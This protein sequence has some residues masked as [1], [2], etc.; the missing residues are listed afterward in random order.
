MRIDYPPPANRG[1][2]SEFP[3]VTPNYTKIVEAFSTVNNSFRQRSLFDICKEVS[4]YNTPERV[5]RFFGVEYTP[6]GAL[7]PTSQKLRFDQFHCHKNT[8]SPDIE[9]L[10]EQDPNRAEEE[11][12][13]SLLDS[14]VNKN[15]RH[16]DLSG[17][18]GKR[19]IGYGAQLYPFKNEYGDVVQTVIKLVNWQNAS[20]RLIP[21]ASW[22]YDYHVQNMFFCVPYPQKK[23]ILYNLDLL[24][25]VDTPTVILTDSIEIAELNQTKPDS[26]RIVWTSWLCD[27]TAHDAYDHV[28]WSPLEKAGQVFLLIT[29][30]SGVSLAEAYPKTKTLADYLQKNEEIE[31]LKY[32]QVDIDF[33][34]LVKRGYANM[35][36]YVNARLD[37]RPVIAPKGLFSLEGDEFERIHELAVDEVRVK[38][39]K[40]YEKTRNTESDNADRA[41]SGDNDQKSLPDYLLRPVIARR[42]ITMLHAISGQGKTMFASSLCA[43]IVTRKA[44]IES[45]WWTCPKDGETMPRKVLYFD[46]EMGN[47]DYLARIK[48]S[49]TPYIPKKDM[50]ENFIIQDML[51][52]ST[53]Y[54]V[55]ANHQKI[56]N[57]IKAAKEQGTP[58]Q[59]VDL[60]VFDSYT[61]L[62]G[63]DHETSWAKILRLM[64][65]I[66]ET[67]AGILLIHHSLETSGKS[68]GSDK[69]KHDFFV[70]LKLN[71]AAGAEGN[72]NDPMLVEGEKWRG[73]P[74]GADKK[75][76]HVRLKKGG[77]W[78]ACPAELP[79]A[80][81]RDNNASSTKKASRATEEAMDDDIELRWSREYLEIIKHYEEVCKLNRDEIAW[82][83][84]YE[85]TRCNDIKRE[86]EAYLKMVQEKEIIADK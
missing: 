60:V 67:N 20:K 84:G 77:K 55:E 58:G 24:K 22:A 7:K 13:E 86:R 72:L 42:K 26:R 2:L 33:G 8:E 50:R 40:F 37:S 56:L 63:G 38:K 64:K 45:K 82:L 76:F 57:L 71:R 43:A 5:C 9:R 53:D 1:A 73:N 74:S 23:Q 79:E 85:K 16:V 25:T 80:K 41:T 31:K 35:A 68:T 30:H 4:P 70:Q 19:Y 27:D 46:F 21:C 81:E 36:S 54:L 65:K 14:W 17:Y 78:E 3:P 6:Y 62:V 34:G 66:T 15:E 61:K 28:D 59:P 29:N 39:P 18:I 47:E 11:L 69:K 49:V 48:T 32:I 75:P 10:R 52:D 44:P 12:I 51:D 83:M